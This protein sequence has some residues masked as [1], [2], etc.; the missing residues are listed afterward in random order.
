MDPYY[1]GDA[2]A[3]N[4]SWQAAKLTNRDKMIQALRDFARQN[5][6]RWKSKLRKMWAAGTDTGW[7][8]YARNTM[9]TSGLDR[10]KVD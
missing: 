5:G 8:R 2:C 3:E 1:T 7:L 4:P 9:G 6:P 10:L